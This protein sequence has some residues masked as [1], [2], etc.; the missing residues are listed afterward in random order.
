ML[1][2]I[3]LSLKIHTSE[4]MLQELVYKVLILDFLKKVLRQGLTI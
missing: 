3:Q 4:N 2:S 1:V